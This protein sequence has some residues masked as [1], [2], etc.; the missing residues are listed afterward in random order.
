MLALAKIIN[1]DTFV[2]ICQDSEC[3]G[4]VVL[5]LSEEESNRNRDSLARKI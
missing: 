1:P 4:N 2:S 5:Y 3:S